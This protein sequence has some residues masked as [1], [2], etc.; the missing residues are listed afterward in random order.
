MEALI[1]GVRGAKKGETFECD[2]KEAL[3]RVAL[4][5][6]IDK[7]PVKV[8][9]V[10]AMVAPGVGGPLI[11][12]GMDTAGVP[13][14]DA[15]PVADVAAFREHPLIPSAPAPPVVTRRSKADPNGDPAA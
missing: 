2:E 6:A 4:G 15:E 9:E 13:M 7:G 5:Q 8:A 14:V 1:D 3:Q 10:A 11:D 12:P